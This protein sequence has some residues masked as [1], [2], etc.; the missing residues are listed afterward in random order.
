[1][2]T[3]QWEMFDIVHTVLPT[4]L[5]LRDFY[6][7][8]SRLWQHS[9]DVRYK[10]RGKFKTYMQLG[11]AVATGKVSLK[12]AKRGL[13]MAKTFSKPGTFLAAHE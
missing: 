12:N 10:Y 7:E 11:A 4:K 6:E 3:D 1:V 2:T 8:Y 5:P 13:G 9:L